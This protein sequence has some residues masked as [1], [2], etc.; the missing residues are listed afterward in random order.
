MRTALVWVITQRV[1]VSYRRFGTTYQSH[2]Q[3]VEN[4]WH[5]TG[6]PETLYEGYRHTLRICNTHCFSTTTMVSRTRLN[7]MLQ[8]HWLY[9]LT[10]VWYNEIQ[11]EC[12]CIH[13]GLGWYVVLREQQKYRLSENTGFRKIFGHKGE[14]D[15][16]LEKMSIWVVS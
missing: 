13:C 8:L 3:G 16:K 1:V 9:Y 11:S 2:L 15:M 6:C 10:V 14:N 7:V 5:P 4:R 12:F